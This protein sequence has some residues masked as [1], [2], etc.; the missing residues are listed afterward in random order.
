MSYVYILE[1][2]TNGRYY[3]GSTDNLK[4]RLNHHT[5]GHTP[6]TRRFGK[7]NLVFSQEYTSLKEAGIIERKLKKLKRRDYIER[8]V[9]DGFIKM[10][11]EH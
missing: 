11:V 2:V 8:I 7:I 1:S 4:L 5:G 3:I 10:K 9:K 6:S